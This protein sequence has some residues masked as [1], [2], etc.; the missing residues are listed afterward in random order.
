M[1]GNGTG[2]GTNESKKFKTPDNHASTESEPTFQSGESSFHQLYLFRRVFST[3]GNTVM[4]NLY[5][6]D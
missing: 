5:S 3:D 6:R 2:I 1:N 4:V